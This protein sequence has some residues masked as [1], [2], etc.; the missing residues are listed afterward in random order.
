[1]TILLLRLFFCEISKSKTIIK[2]APFMEVMKPCL[3]RPLFLFLMLFS[4]VL[5]AAQGQTMI[6]AKYI[7][8]EV[9]ELMDNIKCA[10]GNSI[11][12]P[13][14]Y[15]AACLLALSFYPEL[16]DENIKFVYGKGA[17]SMAARPAPASLFKNRKNR[18]YLIFI[19]TQ[20][21]N[22][23]LLLPQ[24]DFNAQVGIIGHELAHILYYKGKSSFR[25]VLDGLGYMNKSYRAKF[26]KATD[27]ETIKRGLG[28][29]LFDFSSCTHNSE[30]VPEKY[31]RYKKKIYLCPQTISELLQLHNEDSV[32]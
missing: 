2:L 31:K 1:L 23:G 10:A 7:Q 5:N 29:Q 19:N 17:Y 6:K 22:H 4:V 15:E 11:S 3:S 8:E 14:E 20:S 32:N 21:K 30:H 18:E 12:Y 9:A 26:E 24:V 28:W 25:I 13:E 16:R 27:L